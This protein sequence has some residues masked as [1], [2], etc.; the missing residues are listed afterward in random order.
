MPQTKKIYRQESEIGVIMQK[1]VV[2]NIKKK[3]QILLAY[4]LLKI[5]ENDMHAVSDVA[6]D[7]RCLEAA[8]K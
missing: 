1:K 6:N 3:K 4:M 5:E 2:M 8:R 7:I